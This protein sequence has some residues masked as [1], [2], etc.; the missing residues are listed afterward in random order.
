LQRIIGEDIE[1]ETVLGDNLWSVH[2][3]PSQ[4]D[5]VIMNLVVNARDAMPEGGTLDIRTA[6][7]S[8]DEEHVVHH[9]DAEPGEYV[10][11]TVADTGMGM[12][13]GVQARMFEPFFTTKGGG[14]GTG[15]GLS[16]V[17]G[18]VK[19]N[20]GSIWV[21]SEVGQGTAFDIYLPREDD[22]EIRPPEDV[23]PVISPRRSRGTETILV[24][25]DATDVRLLTVEILE[26]NG[27]RT[28]SAQNGTEA[29][30]V[31]RQHGGPIHLLF[32]DLVMPQMSGTELA[33]LL[34][35]ER[36]DLRVLY[37]SGYADRPLV[38]QIVLDKTAAFLRKPFTMEEVTERVRAVLDSQAQGQVG[39]A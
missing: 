38:R 3:D 15:L 27:Y 30:Q 37:M 13:A 21:R 36:P 28:L 20:N 23:L 26:E 29:I 31:S 11:L 33:G 1:L 12:D 14:E 5:Q 19:Q 34:Q 4:V 25:E 18:I 17:F 6:N 32:T 2:M 9:L 39:V 8:L 24:V 35:A 16:T 10:R 22:V 7:A